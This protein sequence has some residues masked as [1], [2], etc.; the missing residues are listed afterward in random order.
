MSAVFTGIGGFE[1]LLADLRHDLTLSAMGSAGNP[2]K[3]TAFVN[4]E[5][6]DVSRRPR[7][8]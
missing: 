4:S 2:K 1:D 3:A 6:K 7:R 5:T 8:R